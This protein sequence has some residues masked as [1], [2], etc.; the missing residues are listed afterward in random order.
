MTAP[1]SQPDNLSESRSQ[2]N[3]QSRN[4]RFRT[5]VADHPQWRDHLD[6]RHILEAVIEAGIQVERDPKTGQDALVLREKRRDGSPGAVRL[7]FLPSASSNGKGPK[8]IWQPAGAKSDELFYYTVTLA[9]LKRLIAEAD[10]LLYIV[11]GE[12][13]VWSLIR[14][15]I[16]NA[17]GT[18]SAS[19]IPP[20]IASILDELGVRK[21]IY[22]ADND[23]AGDDG[24]AKLAALLL[25]A[26]WKGEAEFRK[27]RG[28]GIPHKGDANN[29]LCHHYPDLAAARAALDALP[30]FL[31][32]I[33][34]E[35]VP[36]ISIA[37]GYNDPRFDAIKEAVRIA[38]DAHD[39]GHKGFSKKKFRCL[40][41]QHE[42]H[43]ASANWHRDGFCHCFGC[44][45][46]FNAVQMAEWLGIPWRALLGRRRQFRPADPIDLSAAPRE[47]ESARGFYDEPPD[48]LIRLMNKCYTTMHSSLYYVIS[49]LRSAGHLPEGFTV[50]ELINAAPLVGCELKARAIYDNF[51][52]ARHGDDHPII[53][54]FDPSEDA[55]SRNCKFSLRPTHDIY[56]QL[57]RCNRF[58]VY[59]KEFQTDPDTILGFEVF[60]AAT[61]GSEFAITLE[62]AL[63]PLME[64]QK[65]PYERLLR[66]CEEI[67]AREEAALA[68]RKVTPLP[69]N[70][71]IRKKSDLPA[72]LARAIFDADGLNRSRAEW[73]EILGISYSSVGT[74]LDR[75]GIKRTARIKLVKAR[76]KGELLSKAG[77]ERARIMRVETDEG[78]QA[79]DAA[80]E[81][82]GEVIAT[83]QPPAEHEIISE[84]QPEIR[85]TGAKAPVTTEPET[86]SERANNME[87][88][89]KWQ[90]ASWDPQ[91]RYWEL[92]KVCRLKHGYQVKEDV[93]IYDPE[94]KEIW[95][96]PSSDDLVRLIVE[97]KPSKG[98]EST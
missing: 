6:S 41:P 14:L 45:K 61:L 29:L 94:S 74:V 75:A 9:E 72:G 86:K 19:D 85:P 98:D 2:S 1:T 15:L 4:G 31:P 39:Y 81:I 60:A 51:E 73:Q 76:S 93:G 84:R 95:T 13:D 67:I 96:N 62:K 53:A 16:R 54:K 17:V 35:P 40:D 57:R 50:Q 64:A 33:E 28:E 20:D 90:K 12:V 52:E 42:D 56:D 11:E 69:P 59:E 18:Y 3:H 82:R 79:F 92:I 88:P 91:F 36:K 38:L 23:K 89:G 83:L 27:V 70:W 66:K 7:R 80:M 43:E 47:L 10:G 65:Q 22:L 24:A 71:K 32:E 5:A 55:Q 30:T 87:K 44:G 37:D 77:K 21:I 97:I 48:S 34:P 49:R 8:V 46:D 25:Q 68:D 26:G 63:E 58:R 78:S